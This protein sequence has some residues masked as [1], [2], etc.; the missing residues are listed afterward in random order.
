MMKNTAKI[1][2]LG[3]LFL[4]NSCEKDEDS[5]QIFALNSEAYKGFLFESMKIINFPN[6]QNIIPDFTVLVQTNG[7]GEV[8]SPYLSNPNLEN[9]FF[10]FDELEDLKNAQEVFDSIQ[11]TE[12]NTFQKFALDIKPYQIWLIKTNSGSVG[13]ILITETKTENIEDNPFAEIKFKAKKLQ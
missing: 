7:S 11:T 13:K 10:L 1:L 6:S 8:L 4:F 5:T 3:M 12:I 2:A 9:R